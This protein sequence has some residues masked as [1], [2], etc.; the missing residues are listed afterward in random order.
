[1]QRRDGYPSYALASVAVVDFLHIVEEL[2]WESI[3][4]L[5]GQPPVKARL[6]F[7]DGAGNAVFWLEELDSGREEG[8][9]EKFTVRTPKGVF[10]V[11]PQAYRRL[12][13][14]WVLL[15]RTAREQDAP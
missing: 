12:F 7:R 10:D 3:A 1:M 13:D 14:Q 4:A 11:K 9:P 5:V 15:L 6:E 2:E 8:M